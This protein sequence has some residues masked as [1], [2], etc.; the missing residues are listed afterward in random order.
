MEKYVKPFP[1][2]SPKLIQEILQYLNIDGSLQAIKPDLFFLETLINKYVCT[3]PF[4]T[5]S[6]IVKRVET[7][8]TKDCPRWPQEFWYSS[9]KQGCGGTCFESQYALFAL[10]NTLGYTGYLT[11]NPMID[12]TNCHAAIV[13]IIDE[14]KW[15]VDVTLP[16]YKPIPLKVNDTTEQVTEFMVYTTQSM[17]VEDTYHYRIE[18]SPHPVPYAYTLIDKPVVNET[19]RKVLTSDYDKGGFFLDRVVINKVVDGLPW[20]FNS[21]EVP[22]QL[23]VFAKGQRI[24]HLLNGQPAKQ[25][26]KHFGIDSQ[27]INTALNA[28]A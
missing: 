27:L 2:L 14:M 16:L 19:Y 1:K 10:L 5:A 3:V 28:L 9:I 20:R 15:I 17:F 24:D 23:N 25:I 21:A 6:R 12:C 13:V 18:R 22:W 26:G 8:A 4:E 11:I 7:A